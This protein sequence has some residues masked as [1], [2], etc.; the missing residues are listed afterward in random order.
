MAGKVGAH[1]DVGGIH[2]FQIIARRVE[3]ERDGL[4]EC[5]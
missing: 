2:G 5:P 1:A 3:V 4:P